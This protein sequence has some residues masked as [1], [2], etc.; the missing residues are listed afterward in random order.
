MKIISF[1]LFSWVIFA[2][3]Q[4]KLM[5]IHVDP[6]PQSRL[7]VMFESPVHLCDIKPEHF[8]LAEGPVVAAGRA[9]GFSRYYQNLQNQKTTNT[10][11]QA[12]L[13]FKGFP[14]YGRSRQPSKKNIQHFKT[15][16]FLFFLLLW[17]IFARMDPDSEYES[18]DLI[19][20][21]SNPDSDPKRWGEL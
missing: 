14:S 8:G 11:P 16:N 17:V 10:Y 5:R 21:G 18:T 6:D 12:S 3:Q 1:F 9:S 20:S 15:Y 4:L 7:K 2:L 13:N 19:E